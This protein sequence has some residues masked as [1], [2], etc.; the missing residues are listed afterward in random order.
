MG[1]PFRSPPLSQPL[2]HFRNPFRTLDFE[3]RAKGWV[4]SLRAEPK[5]GWPLCTRPFAAQSAE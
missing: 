5:D 4:V 2:S 3:P 1:G